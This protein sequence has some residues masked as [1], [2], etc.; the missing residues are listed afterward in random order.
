MNH[1]V[2]LIILFLALG[3]AFG[4]CSDSQKKTLIDF[5]LAWESAGQRGDRSYLESTFA[6]DFVALPSMANKSQTIDNILR[7]SERNKANPNLADSVISDNYIISCTDGTATITHRLIVTVKLPDGKEET[8]YNRSVHVLEKRSGRWQAVT[9]ANHELSDVAVLDYLKRDW[10]LAL[11]N[12]DTLWLERNLADDVSLTNL[13]G[14]VSRRAKIIEQVKMDKNRFDTA[15]L[16]DVEIRIEGGAAIIT[17]VTH[18]IGRDEKSQP[19]DRKVRFTDTLIRRDGRW[20]I[21]ATQ[22][23]ALP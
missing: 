23:I 22:E 17:G 5:D 13:T 14:G 1:G 19:I 4:Q 3:P 15:A 11:V 16:S 2:T 21:W 12:R 20:L 7:R 9:N 10:N 18:F 8:F 6:D